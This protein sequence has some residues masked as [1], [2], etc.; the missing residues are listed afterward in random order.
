MRLTNEQQHRN[1]QQK[2]IRKHAVACRIHAL[3]VDRNQMCKAQRHG[4]L[5]D[6]RRLKAKQ[7]QV[8]PA[9]HPLDGGQKQHDHQKRIA[10]QQQWNRKPVQMMIVKIRDQQHQNHAQYR[11]RNLADNEVVAVSII[12][13][14]VGVTGGKQHHK[15][16]HHQHQHQK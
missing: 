10:H 6:F 9:V 8:D 11:K 5:G 13:I 3:K 15:A 14:G 2:H 16:D 4:K 1:G 7:P 12:I